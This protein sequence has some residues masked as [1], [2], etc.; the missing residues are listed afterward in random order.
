MNG[1]ARE[2][3]RADALR[4]CFVTGTDTD[5]GKTRVSAALLHWLATQGWRGAGYKPVA[6]GME[7]LDGTWINPDVRA[8]RHA[9]GVP[10]TDAEVGPCQFAAACAPHIAAALEGRR[11]ARAALL[12]GAHR[13]AARADRLV[14][15]GAGGF[16]VPLGEDFDGGDLA[17]DLGLPVVLVVGL[18]LGCL[19]HA[20]LSAEA[21]AAR[22]LRLAGWIGNT[23]DPAM[24]HAGDNLGFLFEA[25]ERHGAPCLGVVP[26]LDSAAPADLLVWLDEPAL[27][28]VFEMAASPLP[29][30]PETRVSTPPE[31]YNQS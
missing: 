19:N 7:W 10:L 25:M 27:R 16:R 5:V 29:A 6:A 14:I 4:G 26:R 2:R 13:L 31:I 8:L 21:V 20:L 30:M 22:G 24:P 28:T 15:E 18:R 11:I 12:A 1:C 9:S 3:G 17:A 23:I